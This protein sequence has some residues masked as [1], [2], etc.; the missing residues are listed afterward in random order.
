MHDA[1]GLCCRCVRMFIATRYSFRMSSAR[2]QVLVFSRIGAAVAHVVMFST[3]RWI[4]RC[5]S[6]FMA[7]RWSL[8]MC[9]GEQQVLHPELSFRGQVPRL[10]LKLGK[11]TWGRKSENKNQGNRRQPFLVKIVLHTCACTLCTTMR[12]RTTIGLRTHATHASYRH[13]A[14]TPHTHTTH[15]AHV[16]YA[17]CFHNATYNSKAI[18]ALRTYST[19]SSLLPIRLSLI[20]FPHAS[21]NP[22]LA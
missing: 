13:Y 11:Q 5:A 22:S 1:P 2:K 18:T 19:H 12:L 14:R 15:V 3:A 17:L 10:P 20:C 16:R 4:D 21:T 8:R 9:T 6:R 7:T